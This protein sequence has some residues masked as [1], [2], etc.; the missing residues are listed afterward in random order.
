MRQNFPFTINCYHLVQQSRSW[1]VFWPEGDIHLGS[2]EDIY[3]LNLDTAHQIMGRHV[4]ESF[5]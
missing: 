3:G 1:A 5:D 2:I 4:M